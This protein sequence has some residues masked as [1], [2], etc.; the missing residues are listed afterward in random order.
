[1]EG[2]S[3]GLNKIGLYFP[4]QFRIIFKYGAKKVFSFAIEQISIQTVESIF[5]GIHWKPNPF[6]TKWNIRG[7][8]S[9]EQP[10]QSPLQ[11]CLGLRQ[12]PQHNLKHHVI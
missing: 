3:F 4:V 7:E 10:S 6:A 2:L 12:I 11:A 1:M 8:N 9:V 5:E